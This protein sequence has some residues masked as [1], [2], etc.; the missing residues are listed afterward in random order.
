MVFKVT[1]KPAELVAPAGPTPHELKLL[2]DI[3]DQQALRIHYTVVQIFPYQ[4][5]MA[6]KDPAHVIREALS[7]ALVFYYPFAG[8]LREGPR[9]KLMVD[10]T[11]EGVLFMEADADVTLDHFGVDFLPPFPCFDELLCDVPSSHDGIINSPLLLFQV[12]RLKCGGFIFVI[13]VNHTMCDGSG[14]MQFLKG[15][16][17]IAQGAGKPSILPV[18][19]RE[20]LCARDPPRVTYIHPEYNQL[21]LQ[22]DNKSASFKPCHASF[23]FGS[24]EIDAMRFLLPPHIAQSSNTFDVLTACLWRCHTAALHWQNPNQ[25]VRFMCV[26]NARFEPCRLNPPLPEGYYGNAFVLPAAVSTVAKLC[27]RPLSY[28]LEL[29]KKAKKEASEEYVHSTADLMAIKGRPAL[30]LTGSFIVSDITKSEIRDVDYGWGK[31]LYI[32]PDKAG[33]DDVP[34]LSY[35]IPYTNSKGEY[36]RVVLICL[37]EE[38]MKRFEKELHGILQIK[39]KQKPIKSISN[40]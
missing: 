2:S 17:E 25:E 21:P 9:G 29:V 24:K 39:D 12:T 22:D 15:I 27:G 35:F 14:F 18:W 1:R 31:P 7:K 38:A 11:G 6:G 5:S 37:P 33:I 4:A 19:C 10:C 3:D 20:L 13:R 30:S 36:G 8:R 26:A 32:G 16:A 40:L 34:G 28:A 23:F